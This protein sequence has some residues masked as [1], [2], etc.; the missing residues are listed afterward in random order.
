MVKL[1]TTNI[2]GSATKKSW[3]QAQVFSIN[4]KKKILVVIQLT[5][6]D[7]DSLV[8]LATVGAEILLELENKTAAVQAQPI[9]EIVQSLLDEMA[10]E[11]QIELIVATLHNDKLILCGTGEVEAYL[12][13]NGRMG[14]LYSRQGKSR[15]IAGKLESNDL[16]FLSTTKLVNFIG[17]KKLQTM[18]IEEETPE[19]L[20]APLIHTQSDSSGFGAIVASVSEEVVGNEIN[21]IWDKIKINNIK[22]SLSKTEPKKSNLLIGGIIFLA[23]VLMIGIGVLKR[24][25]QLA[26]TEFN[27]LLI[28]VE[29]SINEATT[30]G[31][32]NTE[33]ARVLLTQSR[34]QVENYLMLENLRD[35]YKLK[36]QD[37]IKRI[38]LADEQVF[39]KNEIQLTTLVD[40]SILVEGLR[41]SQMKSDGRDSLIFIDEGDERLVAMNIVDR[42]RQILE[43]EQDIIDVG[44]FDTKLYGLD[45]SGVFEY[46]WKGESAKRVVEGDEFW[47]EPVL[48]ETFAGNV[49]V[50]DRSQSEIWKYSTLGGGEFGGRNRWFAA[51]ITPDLSNVVDMKISGDIW[52]L[53]SS[54]KLERYSRGAPVNFSME[55]FPAKDEAK[56]F[57]DPRAV[58]VSESSIYV[59]E[60]GASRIVVFG[61]DGKYQA[62]YLNSEFAKA[63]DLEIVDNKGYVL[64][65]NA[66]KEFGL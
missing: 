46:F 36:A 64:I 6:Q 20:L 47:V 62:Q 38:E 33:K 45:K 17:I 10:R 60:S 63:S 39:K 66:V 52:L 7:D 42:S 41:S 1:Q 37:L 11:I 57:V 59:L 32:L 2:V 18:L 5:T 19:E 22:V 51:T 26:E 50:L 4:D 16:L 43:S 24:N 61:D 44:M 8:D 12:I 53:T 23:L 28:S 27:T 65:E 14:L 13:R 54:G 31:E 3:S 15:V 9:E 48:L 49:Y 56:R 21:S 34:S 29:Q 55:G 30:I 58:W 25:K 40:L 35:E